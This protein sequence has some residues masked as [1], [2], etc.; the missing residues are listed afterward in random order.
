MKRKLSEIILEIAAQGL[1]SQRYYHSNVMHALVYLAHV[2]WNRDTTIP[3]Y[4]ED[5]YRAD[6]A[7]FPL[8]KSKMRR[9]LISEDWDEIL[10]TMLAYK[11]KHFPDDDRIIT[12]CAYTE[13]GTFQVQ[14]E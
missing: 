12:V 14:W 4:L 11:R 7:K 6:L 9:E 5:T 8:S 10:A 1:R 3:D 2:A 13:R